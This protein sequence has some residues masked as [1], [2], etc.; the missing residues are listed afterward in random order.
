MN[1]VFR[2]RGD[3]IDYIPATDVDWFTADGVEGSHT[4]FPLTSQCY[5]LRVQLQVPS[6]RVLELCL[7][8]NS[9][10]QSCIDN[11]SKPGPAQLDLQYQVG[12]LCGYSDDT[13]GKIQVRSVDGQG[14][15]A[16]YV[17]AFRYDPC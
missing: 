2:Q 12:G 11:K 7:G 6:G 14:G 4:C 16:P 15:C 13:T 3:A 1:A 17:I 9:C 8:Q 10:T 5:V